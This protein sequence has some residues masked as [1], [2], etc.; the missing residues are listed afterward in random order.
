MQN[1]NVL[2][3]H[4]VSDNQTTIYYVSGLCG[5]GKTYGMGL[6]IKESE[7]QTKFI[8]TTPSRKLADEIEQQLTTLEITDVHKIYLEEDQQANVQS[9]IISAIQEINM[10]GQGVI[11]C[12]QQIFPRIGFFENR[13]EWVLIVDEI[14]SVDRFSDPTLPY[15][16]NIITQYITATEK[17]VGKTMRKIEPASQSLGSNEDNLLDIIRPIIDDVCNDHFVSYTDTANWDKLVKKNKISA[18]GDHKTQYGN[19]GNKLYFLRMLQ[20]SVF[21]GFQQVV[22]MGANF[23]QSLL[24]KYWSEYCGVKFQPFKPISEKL[25]YINYKNGD[26]LTIRYLQEANWSKT[27]SKKL[28]NGQS[29]LE[30]HTKSVR[31]FML[32]KHF[33]YMTNNSDKTE[34]SNATKAPVICHGMNEYKEID[35]IY[36]S[37]ALN[38]Q[39]KHN[40]MLVDLGINKDFIKNAMSHEVAYQAIM[41][42]SLRNPDSIAQV[43]AV[44][45]DKSTAEFIAGLFPNCHIAPMNGVLKKVIGKTNS[46]IKRESRLQRIINLHQLNDLVN[47]RP[48]ADPQPQPDEIAGELLS[49]NPIVIEINDKIS[50]KEELDFTDLSVGVSYMS[51]IYQK[52]V[53]ALDEPTPLDFVKLM[54]ELYT[55]QV[56]SQKTESFLF[57]NVTFTSEGRSLSNAAYASMVIVDIDDGDLSPAKFKNIF[58]KNPNYKHSFFMCNSFSRSAEKPNNF[59]AVFFISSKVNDED[60]R[61]VQA[62]ICEILAKH[63][64]I[65]CWPRDRQEYL[66][67]NPS[68][69][70]SGVDKSKDHTASFF[71]VPSKVVTR[72]GWAF[73]IRCNLK[74]KAE[75]KRYAID[76]EKVLQYQPEE[77]SKTGLIYE[78]DSRPVNYI[79][80]SNV[81]IS[82]GAIDKEAIKQHIKSGDF[83]SLGAHKIYGSMAR[84]MYSAGFTLDE[85]IELTPYI[86]DSKTNK[87]ALTQWNAWKKYDSI[88]VGTL[89]RHLGLKRVA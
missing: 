68:A 66:E 44:V 45:V 59:R 28:D 18:D 52:S 72:E 4:Q 25:R 17:Y 31:D 53:V 85:F 14:P 13:N 56:I 7:L 41:R 22:M 3:D 89:F 38:N 30:R 71:Y 67:M 43:T 84:A 2:Q 86:S 39:P 29:Y 57:N 8:I 81:V 58:T 83:R 48:N 88:S 69:K 36:F 46:E 60:Y 26:R 1:I 10:L 80:N 51:N 76:I 12:T 62:Y 74:D 50:Q 61:G 78:E 54:K 23:E 5:S 16:H 70:F 64:Y 73:F 20:P 49:L 42:T 11:I 87:E 77:S 32:D 24:Y 79:T 9:R 33:L 34:F 35:N 21:G 82:V 27:A 15:T 19:E 47:P 37:P 65:T 75:L 40:A 63:G 55:N 6:F